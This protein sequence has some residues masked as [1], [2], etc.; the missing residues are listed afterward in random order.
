MQH[1]HRGG[2]PVIAIYRYKVEIGNVLK[3]VFVEHNEGRTER[4][5]ITKSYREF[6]KRNS[7]AYIG[8]IYG[9]L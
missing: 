6:W 8:R 3:T 9:I 1:G 2:G 4:K 7:S 5:K